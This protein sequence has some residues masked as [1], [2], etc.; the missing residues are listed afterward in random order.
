MPEVTQEQFN[1]AIIAAGKER[2][3]ANFTD[4]NRRAWYERVEAECI[5]LVNEEKE[6][7]LPVDYTKLTQ[8]ERRIVRLVYIALQHGKCMHCN[9][10]L[11]TEPPMDKEINWNLFPDGFLDH[12][13]HL[14]HDHDT[15]MTRG[16]VHAYCNAYL[17]CYE[18]R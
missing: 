13:I 1:Q 8:S 7:G 6:A 18:G 14:D 16:A 3:S 15:G 10:D 2:D 11:D 17:W 12:P 4:F 5:R 9:K